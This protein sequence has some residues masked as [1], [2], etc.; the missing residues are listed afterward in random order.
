M[1]QHD[2]PQFAL[3]AAGKLADRR[4]FDA[5]TNFRSAKIT[6]AG[7]AN[8]DTIRLFPEHPGEMPLFGFISSSASLGSATVAIGDATTANRY[9]NAGTH[10]TANAPVFFGNATATHRLLGV[11]ADV[12]LTI[13]AAALP[14]SGEL[15]VT[16]VYAASE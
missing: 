1:P 6:M 15:N 4:Y 3:Y 13:G 5:R 11:G 7:Q 16:M 14:S 10:T 12:L 2:S 9:K 8:G